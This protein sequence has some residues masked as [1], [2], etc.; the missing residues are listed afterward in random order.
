[1]LGTESKIPCLLYVLSRE[2]IGLGRTI[3]K[4]DMRIKVLKGKK[5]NKKKGKNIKKKK[6]SLLGGTQ[7]E[8]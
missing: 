1:M 2:G 5:K 6:I 3:P 4:G 7:M 8:F